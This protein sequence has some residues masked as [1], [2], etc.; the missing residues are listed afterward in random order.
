MSLICV[1]F[2]TSGFSPSNV[3]LKDVLCNL[4]WIFRG[5]KNPTDD[6]KVLK[7]QKKIHIFN[8]LQ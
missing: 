8:M 1:I 7:T 6:A 2:S 4:F 3:L 5:V